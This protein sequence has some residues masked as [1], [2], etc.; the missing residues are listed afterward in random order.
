MKVL[1]LYF[2]KTGHTLEAA[3]AAAEGIRSAGSEADLVTVKGFDTA[4]LKDY[5]AFIVASPC[6]AGS[7]GRAFLPRP[8]ERALAALTGS[9]LH[10]TRCGGIS[11]HSGIGAVNTVRQIGEI[12]TGK[13]CR[14]FRSGPVARAGVPLSVWKGPSVSPEDEARFRA[15]GDAFVG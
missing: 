15:Y 2:T 1:I 5:D 4:R 10:G 8:L 7:T 11:V 14:D 9:D 12:L 3:N 6:W 13:G